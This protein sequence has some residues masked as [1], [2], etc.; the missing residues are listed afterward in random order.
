MQSQV[1]LGE[2]SKGD[3]KQKRRGQC[4]HRDIDWSDVTQAKGCWQ[5]PEAG[6]GKEL[7]FP[8]EPSKC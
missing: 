2:G 8:R 5:P 4:D 6:R 1:S 7:I 3:F